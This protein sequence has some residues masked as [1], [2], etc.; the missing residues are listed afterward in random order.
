MKQLILLLVVILAIIKNSFSNG[1]FTCNNFLLNAYLY[2]LLGFILIASAVDI[3]SHYNIPSLYN[4]YKSR[5][6]RLLFALL[7]TIGLLMAVITMPPKFLIG[8]H[9]LWISWVAV[10]GYVLYP[11]AQLNRRIFEQTKILVLS[12]MALLTMI[13]FKWPHKISLTWGRTLLMLLMVLILVRI[14]GFFRPYTSQTHFMISYAAVVLFSFFML[15]DTKQLI[16][17]AK[18]CVKAD[19]INDS[20]GVFLDGMNLFVNMFHLRR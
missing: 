3:Y 14:V 9:I 19:Y 12:Y 8:K 15:Y 5:G 7:I 1:G 10:L 2:I 20:L 18:K 17:K 11:L 6:T 4:I 16:V 13:T